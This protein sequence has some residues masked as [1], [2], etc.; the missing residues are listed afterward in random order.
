MSH[1]EILAYVAKGS[2]VILCTHTG[3]ERPYLKTFFR[4]RL[5]ETLNEIRQEEK[6]DDQPYEVVMSEHEQEVIQY[7]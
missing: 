4:A 5:E 6:L 1:H 3:T 2:H 7:V